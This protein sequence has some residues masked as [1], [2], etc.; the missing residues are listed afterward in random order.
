MIERY[1]HW[2]QHE[3]DSNAKMLAMLESVPAGSRDAPRFIRAVSLAAHL[4]ACRENWLEMMR[5][6]EQS[7]AWW[8]DGVALDSL[9]PRFA[10]M[11]AAWA[12]YLAGLTDADLEAD[13]TFG[14]G[15]ASYRWN[16]E[17]QI[18]QLAG[19]AYY[20]RGQIAQLVDALGGETVD[21]DYAD[22][23]IPQDPR[24]G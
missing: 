10:A 4:A 20:H 8:P 21:T 6:A 22:W 15:G 2:Y 16:T 18:F 12:S 17:G 19:H 11:E 7:G 5:G 1:R 3:R 23:A 13:F 24:W 14:D 9:R